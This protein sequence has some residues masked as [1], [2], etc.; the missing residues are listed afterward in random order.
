MTI[1]QSS[2]LTNCC[3]KDRPR[4][5]PVVHLAASHCQNGSRIASSCST[6]IPD[7]VSAILI[8]WVS[9]KT[10]TVHPASV[11]FPALSSRFDTIRSKN[12]WCV[13]IVTDASTCC[14]KLTAG[15]F[16]CMAAHSERTSG[17]TWI[18]FFSTDQSFCMRVNKVNVSSKRCITAICSRDCVS[19]DSYCFVFSPRSIVDCNDI[20][21][22]LNS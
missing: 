7:P 20:N 12:H 1:S 14:T 15:Y 19:T 10:V 13:T 3:T 11:N 2:K 21:G 9:Q 18:G 22:V 16:S 17:A 6:E 4:P 8:P 5:N